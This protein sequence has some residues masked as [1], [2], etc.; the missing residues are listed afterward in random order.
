V[1]PLF[2]QASGE[3]TTDSIKFVRVNVDDS[4]GISS[5]FQIMSIPTIIV[6]D[7]SGSEID[8]EIGPP[9]R[10]RLEQLVRYAGSL[11]DHATKRGAA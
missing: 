7:A 4:P 1:H 9:S 5:A 2:D 11:T 8:R 6:L 3:H 10:R